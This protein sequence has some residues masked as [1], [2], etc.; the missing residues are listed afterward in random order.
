MP[1]T[2]AHGRR[3]MVAAS[4]SNANVFHLCNMGLQLRYL[5]AVPVEDVAT[6]K[7]WEGNDA[8]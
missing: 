7:L 8:G 5:D 1:L 6:H 3:L 4:L 2:D